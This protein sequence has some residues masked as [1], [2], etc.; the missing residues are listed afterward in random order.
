MARKT[1]G[2]CKYYGKVE[3]V[4]G[5]KPLGCSLHSSRLEPKAA[6]CEEHKP[7]KATRKQK[8]A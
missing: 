3:I 7:K 5:Y 1:C 2:S 4:P 8:G 6:A